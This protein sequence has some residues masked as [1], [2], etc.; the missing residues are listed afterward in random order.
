MEPVVTRTMR[1]IIPPTISSTNNNEV[2]STEQQQFRYMD[3]NDGQTYGIQHQH[4]Q[5]DYNAQIQANC[6]KI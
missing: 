3:R 2:S 1:M 4:H 5:N 6:Y